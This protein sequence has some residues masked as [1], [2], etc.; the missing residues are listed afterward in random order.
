MKRRD[1]FTL[2][3]GAAVWPIA[4]HAQQKAMPVV[5]YLYAGS[6]EPYLVAAFRQGLSETGYVEGQNVAIEY[7]W[8]NNQTDRLAALADDLVRRQV[9]VIATPGSLTAPLAAK[10]ATSTIPI[11]FSIGGDPVKVGLVSSFNRPGGNVTGISSLNTEVASKRLGLLHE[12]VPGAARFAL[13]AYRRPFVDQKPFADQIADVQA[14]ASAL[15]RHV[16]VFYAVT[17]GD[18]DASFASIEQNQIEALVLT[19]GPLF[20]NNRA[21]IIALAA[22][23]SV[24]AM[25]AI[26]EYPDAGGLMSYGPSVT[27]EFRQAGIY[28]G[29]VLKGEKPADLP[30]LR[31][32]KFELVINLKTAKSLGISIPSGVLAIADEVIE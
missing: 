3:S 21:H 20:N 13:L 9:A 8:A 17:D 22:R 10:A 4:A 31:A 1:F 11:V 26:R 30:V 32:V 23:Y 2:V 5:G 25:Y 6:A 28:V 15:G 12:V 7:R 24:P 27:E 19:P 14:A 29:R 16:E 18:I